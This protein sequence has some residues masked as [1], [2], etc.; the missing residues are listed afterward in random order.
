MKIGMFCDSYL[1]DINGVVT[2]VV[3]TKNVLEAHGHEVWVISNHPSILKT[4][5]D[6]DKHEIRLPGIVLKK[7]Y[8]YKISS[9]IHIRILKEISK[10]DWDLVH[11]HSEFGVGIFGR[12]VAKYLHIPVVSTYHTTY[13]DYTHYVNVLKMDSIDRFAKM[14]IAKLSKLYGETSTAVIAPSQKTKDM[15]IRYQVN[16]P[17]TVVPTGLDLKRFMPNQSD[18]A[19]VEKTKEGYGVKT[20][21]LLVLYVGRIAKEKSIDVLVEAFGLL[22]KDIKMKLMIVGSGPGVDEIETLISHYQIEDKVIMTGKKFPDEIPLHYHLGDVFV[23]ASKTETQGLTFVEAMASGLPVLASHDEAV[24]SLLIDDQN[25][26]FFNNAQELAEKLLNFRTLS[27]TKRQELSKNALLKAAEYDGEVFYK[28]IISVYDNALKAYNEDYRVSAISYNNDV[29]TLTLSNP[30][31]ELDVMVSVDSFVDYGIRKD[32]IID[33]ELMM[34][35]VED[36]KSVHSYKKAIRYLTLKDRTIQEMTDWFKENTILDNEQILKMIEYLKAKKYLDDR[37]YA[38]SQINKLRNQ[39][40]GKNRIRKELLQ[41]GITPK[42]IDD[43]NILSE[44]DQYQSAL[45]YAK[46]WQQKIRDRS[47]NYKKEQIKSKLIQYGY[48]V[49]MAIAVVDSL[50]TMDNT[51][52]EKVIL[53]RLANKAKTRYNRRYSGSQLRNH[54]FRY[55]SLQGFNYDDIYLVINEMEWEDE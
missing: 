12:I 7:L 45:S 2:S 53:R 48:D 43:L 23:S 32:K 21:E 46:K 24:E 36:E 54:V 27:K 25:G 15:L 6:H 3:T 51:E 50:D 8:G 44:D 47:N 14:V 49:S 1:P 19:L 37:N 31:N 22:P 5:V 26:Y 33:K 20:D 16:T 10:L 39:L 34:K 40:M 38:Q 42:I 17:I 18:L 35:L 41:K 9:P 55:L 4:E 52:S 13:E 11:A 29:V 28:K 30:S